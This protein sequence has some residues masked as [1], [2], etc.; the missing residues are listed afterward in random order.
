VFRP[1]FT[2][3]NV[4]ATVA[5]FIALGGS[6]YAALRVTGA[7]V[8][9]DALTGADIKNLTGKD[10]KNNSLTGADVKNLASGDVRDGGL[11]AADFAAGQL[12]R[13]A[14][15]APG[16]DATNLFAYV[17]D[18]SVNVGDAFVFY[19]KGVTAV[20][21]G[22]VAGDY[23]VTFNRSV[24]GCV[25]IPVAGTGDPQGTT[26]PAN[27]RARVNMV[28]GSPAQVQILFEDDAGTDVDTPFMIAA[29]C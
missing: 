27:G 11:L 4:M 1:R 29:F 14:T 21:D 13:G 25:V 19:G 5:V 16:K 12:P 23:T 22:P 20:D 7:N 10:V 15:G 26:M 2:Y 17:R 18:E 3:A 9:K 24:Y 28:S 8:P 6:S